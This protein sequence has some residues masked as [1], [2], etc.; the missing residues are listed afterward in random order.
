[1]LKRGQNVLWINNCYLSDSI[2]KVLDF[3]IY[4]FNL[5]PGY[6][7]FN[8]QSGIEIIGKLHLK[9]KK[10]SI[11]DTNK[12]DLPD[13]GNDNVTIVADIYNDTCKVKPLLISRMSDNKIYAATR[14]YG[15]GKL[16]IVS[17]P[18]VFTN[19]NILEKDGA[20]L[21]MRIMSQVGDKHMVRYDLTQSEDYITEQDKSKSPLRV[22][23]DN[24]SLRWA[25]YLTLFT[26]LLSLIFTARRRQRVIPVIEPPKN[27]TLSMV[28]HIG[29][30]HYR[31]H[32]N[33]S[34]VLDY[35]KQFSHEMMKKLLV[36]INNEIDLG[37]NLS[38]I[39]KRTGIDADQ[40]S[41][42][43]ERLKEIHT[44][45]DINDTQLSDKET[46]YLID[47]MNNVINNL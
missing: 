33:T 35:Y 42:A 1:M 11:F 27:Q 39:S 41:S 13:L 9:W 26:I 3:D 40:L 38:Y 16:V 31:H 2:A 30:M 19:Y 20:H 36:D 5:S 25:V 8:K 18:Q 10:D 47:I 15:K 21:L 32:D 24:K 29:L 17:W 4:D 43:I 44:D 23:L 46:K 6:Y 12:Y 14:N 37:E 45:F 7:G 28:K 34:L 22:F